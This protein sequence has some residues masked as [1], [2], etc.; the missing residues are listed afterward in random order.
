MAAVTT[1]AEMPRQTVFLKR[2]STGEWSSNHWAWLLSTSV[3]RVASV[4]V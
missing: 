1:R 4:S 3:R 2:G